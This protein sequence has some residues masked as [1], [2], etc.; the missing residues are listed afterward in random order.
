MS[1]L[2]LPFSADRPLP[3]DPPFAFS[4]STWRDTL[5]EKEV[6]AV[7]ALL[8]TELLRTLRAPAMDL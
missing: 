2:L 7:D 1:P 5:Y 8:K 3:L 4:M 6:Q